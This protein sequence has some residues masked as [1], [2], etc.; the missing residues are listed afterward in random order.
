MET[1]VLGIEQSLLGG[2]IAI[3]AVCAIATT[4]ILF[5]V[6]DR[7]LRARLKLERGGAMLLLL[8]VSL[9]VGAVCG[10]AGFFWLQNRQPPPAEEAPPVRVEEQSRPVPPAGSP[11][12]AGSP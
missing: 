5:P 9:V 1:E 7:F 6:I 2:A 3:G 8:A 12:S 4:L 10:T 11:D